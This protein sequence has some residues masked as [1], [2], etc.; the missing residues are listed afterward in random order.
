V[1][2]VGI[3][4]PDSKGEDFFKKLKKPSGDGKGK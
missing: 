2:R 3:F 1:S 4:Y